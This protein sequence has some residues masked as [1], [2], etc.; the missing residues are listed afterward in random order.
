[1]P[2]IAHLYAWR[3]RAGYTTPKQ[4]ADVSGVSVKT[5]RRIENHEPVNADVVR[6]LA[7]VFGVSEE[8]F[9]FKSPMG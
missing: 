5:I 2:R 3:V 9:Q 7:R 4:L 6:C 8:E 1:M